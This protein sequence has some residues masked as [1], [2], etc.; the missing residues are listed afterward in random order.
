MTQVDNSIKRRLTEVALLSGV[1]VIMFMDTWNVTCK[2]A[3]TPFVQLNKV[4][5]V[6]VFTEQCFKKKKPQ[7]AS[8]TQH[9]N[10]FKHSELDFPFDDYIHVNWVKLTSA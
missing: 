6:H 1:A 10:H 7:L 9:S 3:L 5:F 8:L 2:G 4:L